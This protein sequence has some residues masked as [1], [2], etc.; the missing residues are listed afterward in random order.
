MCIRDSL[1]VER[2]QLQR[3]ESLARGVTNPVSIDPVILF[4]HRVTRLWLAYIA[5][6]SLI[7]SGDIPKA[8][9]LLIWRSEGRQRVPESLRSPTGCTYRSSH[10]KQGPSPQ[11]DR[12]LP[13]QPSVCPALCSPASSNTT[14]RTEEQWRRSTYPVSCSCNS[15]W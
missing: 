3:G 9:V 5:T 8:L 4:D 12:L 2:L 10:G 14:L 13:S 1:V 7:P 15:D 11:R 6:Y